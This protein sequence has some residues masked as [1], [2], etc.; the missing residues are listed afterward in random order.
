MRTV[1]IYA[2]IDPT[3]NQ[4]RYIGKT[5]D[6]YN[7]LKHHRNPHISDTNIHKKNWIN[8]LKSKGLNPEMFILDE[9]DCLD[10]EWIIYEQ[11]WISQVKSWGFNLVNYSIGGDNPP[12]NNK[13]WSK[14]KR[15]ELSKNRK[16]KK[17]INVYY[18]NEFMG[19]YEGINVFIREHLGFDRYDNPK[20]F[21]QWSS[22]ISAVL[23][24][25]RT[26]HKK[27]KF[28]LV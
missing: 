20:E 14:E 22:K 2:L 19:I 4:I 21:N 25:K 18:D 27:Y 13:P 26:S 15:E 23:N 7:R 16:D 1:Y 6:P 10:N 3:N 11:Y 8:S 5:V 24:G 17:I 9:I 12:L 28:E